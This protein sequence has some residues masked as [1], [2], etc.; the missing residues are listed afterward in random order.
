MKENARK[1]MGILCCTM[2]SAF[3]LTGCGEKEENTIEPRS[4][5]VQQT[6]TEA[7]PE[8]KIDIPIY[9]GYE[10]LWNDEFDG[11]EV[12]TDIWNYELHEPGWVNQELQEYTSSK[13][14]VYLEDGNLIIKA[15]E[16]ISE[17]GT[18]YYTSGRMTTQNKQDF[19]YGKVVIRAKVPEGQGLWPALWMMPTDENLYGQW[20]KC[21]EIDI[22]EVLGHQ[23]NTAYGT[24]HCGEPYKQQQGTFLLNEGTFASDYHDFSVEWEPGEMR[25]YID[26]TLYHTVN[27]WFSAVEG[28]DEKAYPAPFNQNFYLI[29]NLAVGG[30]WPGN[31][32]ETTNFDNANLLV[33]YVR[34]YQKPEYDTAVTK[35]V[36]EVREVAA[37]ESYLAN[38][39]FSENMDTSDAWTFLLAQNGA[40]SAEI[41]DGMMVISSQDDGD[42]DYSVQ[43]V[44]GNLP[45]EKDGNYQ[46]SFE[47]KASENRDMIICVSAPDNG[48]IRY[49]PDTKASLTTDWQTYTYPFVMENSN[50]PNGRFEFNMGNQNSIAEINIKNVVFEKID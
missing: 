8:N 12:N 28:E 22:M 45:L 15:I 39:D 44:Q 3:V 24:I 27:D 23:V 26:G 2:I 10:L 32:D 36:K 4:V 16:T 48:W 34:V 7:I 42:V 35:P 37:G 6:E 20:P 5:E 25:F 18:P 21:G 47:A 50:D 43:L 49:L 29:L 13:D 31:P 33:D 46:V 14:N 1:G 19:L 9:D 40:G 11:T 17:N 41:K 38:G 30:T